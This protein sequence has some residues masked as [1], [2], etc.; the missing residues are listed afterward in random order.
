MNDR[1]I[2]RSYRLVLGLTT[3]VTCAGGG[4]SLGAA[5]G[6]LAGDHLLTGALIG[7]ALSPLAAALSVRHTLAA[8]RRP[9]E[10]TL[11]EAIWTER[12]EAITRG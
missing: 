11:V 3:A 12:V 4:I 10:E 8:E 6:Y 7:L 9:A 1:D 5:L 2:A